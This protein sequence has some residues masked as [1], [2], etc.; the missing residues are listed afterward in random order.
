VADFVEMAGIV[1]VGDCSRMWGFEVFG[2]LEGFGF[3]S[4]FEGRVLVVGAVGRKGKREVWVEAFHFVR[5]T[6]ASFD[7][8]KC[9][10]CFPDSFG[11][12]A[13]PCSLRDTACYHDVFFSGSIQAQIF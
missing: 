3:A 11:Y 13:C 2:H 1:L 8:N 4:N 12:A 10:T 6:I 5:C 7:Y 9:C